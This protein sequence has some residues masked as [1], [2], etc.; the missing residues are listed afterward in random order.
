[1]ESGTT[2]SHKMRLHSIHFRAGDAGQETSAA[3]GKG[4]IM[5]CNNNNSLWIILIL[6]ALFG[7]GSFNFGCGCNNGCNNGCGND[8]GCGC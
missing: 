8:C 5:M 7:C 3:R 2:R 4:F 6:I 1:M